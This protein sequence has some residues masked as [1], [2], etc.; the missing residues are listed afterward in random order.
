MRQ[1]RIPMKKIVLDT[2][3]LVSSLISNKSYPYQLYQ[4]WIKRLFILVS[5][6]PQLDE[7][8]RVLNYPKLR[9]FID[10]EESKAVIEGLYN[11][12]SIVDELLIIT[13]S[14]DPDDNVILAT[15]IK[16]EADYLV[17]GDKQDLLALKSVQ[18]TQIISA[19]DAVLVLEINQ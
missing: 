18:N 12:A 1:F 10:E 13:L 8:E 15:A 6:R 16:G 19:S 2:N 3:I 14:P 9:R 17:T 11:F 4:G 7:L 5:S